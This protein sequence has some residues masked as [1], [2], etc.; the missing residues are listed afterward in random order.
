MDLYASAQTCT[1]V[2]FD[3]FI[4]YGRENLSSQ[5]QET[6]CI[7][8]HGSNTLNRSVPGFTNLLFA[9]VSECFA[10]PRNVRSHGL[11]G[12]FL[13]YEDAM[14]PSGKPARIIRPLPTIIAKPDPTLDIADV[15]VQ[16]LIC[17]VIS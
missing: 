8:Q 9:I 1:E 13:R 10:N 7:I 2:F 3:F 15:I 5:V 11:N 6:G 17:T 12:A 16:L 4:S 14:H